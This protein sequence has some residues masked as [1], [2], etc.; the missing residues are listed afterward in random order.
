MGKEWRQCKS[1]PD[2][3][4]E[5]QWGCP[6][7]V[8]E[9]RTRLRQYGDQANALIATLNAHDGSGSLISDARAAFTLLRKIVEDNLPSRGA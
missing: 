4:P 3:D 8:Y 6:D 2:V 7:C 9:M 5:H 1:H